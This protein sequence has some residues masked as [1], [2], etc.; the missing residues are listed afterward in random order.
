MTDEKQPTEQKEQ[1]P[2]SHLFSILIFLA[3]VLAIAGGI[4][5]IARRS[6][7]KALAQETEKLAIPTVAVFHPMV[8]PGSEDLVLPSTMQAYVES[9]IFARTSGYLK[10]WYFDIGS[11]VKKGDL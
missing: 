2:K 7:E 11:Q 1:Q 8:E 3:I 4:T 5:L 10:K 9:P 6:Q